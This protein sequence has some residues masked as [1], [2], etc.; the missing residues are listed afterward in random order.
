[1]SCFLTK[2]GAGLNSEVLMLNIWIYLTSDNVLVSKYS[3]F[4]VN[5]P[6]NNTPWIFVRH[7]YTDFRLL[8]GGRSREKVRSPDYV[9]SPNHA[10]LKK[11][12]W[13]PRLSILCLLGDQFFLFFFV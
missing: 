5:L 3:L 7:P 10:Y 8:F 4:R 1:M 11:K 6:F 13:G 2:I 9:T 12:H